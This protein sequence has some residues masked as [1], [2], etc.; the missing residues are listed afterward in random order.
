M[1]FTQ[2]GNPNVWGGLKLALGQALLSVQPV[3]VVEVK[4]G[5]TEAKVEAPGTGDFSLTEGQ[6]A[7][8]AVPTFNSLTEL[9][10]FIR[11]LG[12]R[13]TIQEDATALVTLG[14]GVSAL[15]AGYLVLGNSTSGLE[16]D[17]RSG[18]LI[19]TDSRGQGQWV[20]P[21]SADFKAFEAAVKKRDKTATVRGNGD[22]SLT[23]KTGKATF[24]LRPDYTLVDV[25]E[26]KATEAY[27][28]GEDGRFFVRYPKLNKAQGFVVR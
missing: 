26:G 3:G 12:G 10:L 25:P 13:L 6:M 19:W 17:P 16:T 9:T 28:F 18:H 11:W 24:T 21:V 14:G 2:Q 23:L 7:F 22:G 5:N 15:Q 1:G 27:W 20:F 4:P 8:T